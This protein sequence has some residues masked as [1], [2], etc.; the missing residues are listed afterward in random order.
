M[1]AEPSGSSGS[2][3]SYLGSLISLTSKSEIR[4]EGVL[5]K[6]NTAEAS[7]GLSN[8]RSFGTEGRK[9]DG[10]Q[11]P[12][13]DK[14]YEYILFRGSDIKDLQV[15][16]SPP[17]QTTGPM[18]NDPAIIQSHY[19]QA[20]TSTHLP[21]ASAGSL[22]DLSSHASQLVLPN[23]TFQGSFPSYPPN[24]S[25]GSWGSLLP[26]PPANGS[27]FTTP[28]YW[29]GLYGVSDGLQAQQ[30][31]LIQPLSGLSTTQSMQQSMQ[32]PPMNASLPAGGSNLLALQFSEFPPPPVL[33]PLDNGTFNFHS[34]LLP[35]QFSTVASGS[36]TTLMSNTTPHFALST[37]LPLV[38]PL[39]AVPNKTTVVPGSVMLYNGASELEPSLTGISNSFL[40]EGS[41]PSLVT[42]GQL[43]HPGLTS[44]P[45]S[46]SLQTAQDVEVVQVSSSELPVLTLVEAQAP[47]LPLPSPP[48]YKLSGAP[49]HIRH[50]NRGGRERAR[51]NGNLHPVTRFTEDFDFLTMNE[52]FNKDEVWDH[53]GKSN[54]TQEDGNGSQDEDDAGPS[55]LE[56]KPVYVKDDFFDSLSCNALDRGSL[57]GRT[58]FSERMKMDA[59]TFGDF[60]R[61]HGGGRGRGRGLGRNGYSRGGYYPRSYGYIR[62]GR[63]HGT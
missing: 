28:M 21:T 8:V 54:K 34:P 52:K 23:S 20:A 49:S 51:A 16:S 42:P 9:K 27:G 25:S 15:K 57:N 33:P 38:F 37:S 5:F 12:P 31:S 26:P 55:K 60:T 32:Y 7:I 3:D 14:V 53:L 1:A 19:S 4:Y 10:P 47:I 48:G 22:Q 2:A 41:M 63:G 43:L 6:I 61:H 11:I 30:Q 29:Q 18:Y 58:K 40:N 50:Y 39:T 45:S 62:R 56:V 13:S 59:E 35:G 44:A 24:V 46:Q 36:S 17:V